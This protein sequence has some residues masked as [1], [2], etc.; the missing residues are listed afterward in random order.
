MVALIFLVGLSTIG[1]TTLTPSANSLKLRA[2]LKN[3]QALKEAS[4]QLEVFTRSI[5]EIY[6]TDSNENFYA[7]DRIPGPGYL[8]CPDTNQNQRSNAPC[9]QGRTFVWGRLPVRIASRHIQFIPR[10]ASTPV[11]WYAVDSRYVIQNADFNNPPTKR[12]SPLNTDHPGDARL[13]LESQTDIV[14]LLFITHKAM[15]INATDLTQHTNSHLASNSSPIFQ[16]NQGQFWVLT[17]QRWQELIKSRAEQAT[18]LCT[19]SQEE[20]GW[21]NPCTN[22]QDPTSNC[23]APSGTQPTSNPVGS[24]WRALLC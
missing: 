10:P 11:I 18:E 3:Q 1:F 17:H 16:K 5:P 14:A 22:S 6:A 9:G 23:P 24:N 8:P 19:Q 20:P 15:P 21:F 2:T 12:F 4:R 13:E 7:P